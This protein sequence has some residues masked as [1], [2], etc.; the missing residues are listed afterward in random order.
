MS[1]VQLFKACSLNRKL[2][3]QRSNVS[4]FFSYSEETTGG[5][6]YNT[7]SNRDRVNNFFFMKGQRRYPCFIAD[8]L[9]VRILEVTANLQFLE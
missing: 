6:G 7:L 2:D 3:L 9:N 4:H 1:R 5:G 8:K